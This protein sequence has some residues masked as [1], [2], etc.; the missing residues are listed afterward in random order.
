MKRIA[1]HSVPRSGSTWLGSIFD[2]NPEVCYRYQPLFS[3]AHKGALSEFSSQADIANFFHTIQSSTDDFINQTEA[4]AQ[5]IIP[6]FHKEDG[7]NCVVYKEV[8]YHYILENLLE[9]DEELILVGLIRNPIQVLSSWFNA[10]REFRKDLGWDEYEEWYE[11]KLKNGERREDYFGFKK[12]VETTELLERLSAKY[13][14]RCRIVKYSELSN[15]VSATV[16]SLFEFCGL[17]FNHQTEEFILT[18]TS[19]TNT[20]VYSVFR[21]KGKNSEVEGIK[22]VGIRDSIED[23]IKKNPKFTRYL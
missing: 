3:Y 14:T 11:A 5:G 13:P 15:H 8:R 9:Q 16:K 2:S 4:K 7:Y 10:P 6:S 1:I 17:D 22:N 20:D 12:W 19:T 18:S 21:E 23:F